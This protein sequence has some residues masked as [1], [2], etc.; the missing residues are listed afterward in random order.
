MARTKHYEN[1][2]DPKIHH[3]CT[4]WESIQQHVAIREKEQF[5]IQDIRSEGEIGVGRSH[6]YQHLACEDTGKRNGKFCHCTIGQNLAVL[7]KR[8]FL[9]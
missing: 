2:M 4:V 8:L 1:L 5:P 6:Q 3:L 9:V 7:R